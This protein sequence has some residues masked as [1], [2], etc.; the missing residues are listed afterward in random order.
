[1]LA[2]A[3]AVLSACAASGTNRS[4]GEVIDDKT[5]ATSIKTALLASPDTDGLNIDVEVDRNKVQLNGFVDNQSQVNR[6]GE[7]ARSTSG[8]ESVVNNLRVT[9]GNRQ[10]GEYIDDNSLAARVKLALADDPVVQSLKVDVEVNRGVV[11]LGGFVDSN[12][13]RATAVAVTQKVD[14]VVK[15]VDNLAVR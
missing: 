6:A 5:I 13:E 2:L 10:T 9:E 12:Q 3:C 15:V 8:V 11:S 14:G 4:T 7:I 1:M